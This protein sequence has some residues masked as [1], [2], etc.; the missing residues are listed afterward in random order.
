MTTQMQNQDGFTI[1]E[2]IVAIALILSLIV[3]SMSVNQLLGSGLVVQENQARAEELAREAMEAVMS[4]RARDYGLLQEG[5][6]H[7]VYADQEWRLVSGEEVVDGF[8]RRVVVSR[9]LRGIACGEVVCNL[10]DAGG[11]R[12]E[13]TSEILVQVDWVE[14]GEDKQIELRGLATYWR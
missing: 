9:A 6:F 8:T 10:V 7:P 14:R 2:V 3:G 5:G 1:V 4:V 11:V 13:A 12:D